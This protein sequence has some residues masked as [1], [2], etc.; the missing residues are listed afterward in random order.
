MTVIATTPPTSGFARGSVQPS[1]KLP[2]SGAVV[3]VLRWTMPTK[4]DETRRTKL[5]VKQ[6]RAIDMLLGGSTVSEVAKVLGTARQTISGW[7]NRNPDFMAELVAR[8]T[9]L[10][11]AHVDQITTLVP[12]AI[13]VV[14][15]KV[16]EGSLPAAIHALRAVGLYGGNGRPLG[17]VDAEEVRVQLEETARL[18]EARSQHIRQRVHAQLLHEWANPLG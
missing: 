12:R 1:G 9:E 3:E 7:R 18:R 14:S 5:S 10:R 16:E 2:G 17:P 4:R 13:D 6:E 15:N 11:D 8:R